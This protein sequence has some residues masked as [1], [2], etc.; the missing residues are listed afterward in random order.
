M[1]GADSPFDRVVKRHYDD[2]GCAR[3]GFPVRMDLVKENDEFKIMAELPGMEKDKIKI[4]VE[5]G[6]LT[7]SGERTRGQDNGHEVLRS[8]RFYGNFTRS[9]TLPESIDKSGIS[10]DYKNGLLEVTLPIIEEEKPKEI[11]VKVN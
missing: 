9:F 10:A 11:N 5:N 1:L 2:Q 6:V 8:E 4:M 7:I 3:K